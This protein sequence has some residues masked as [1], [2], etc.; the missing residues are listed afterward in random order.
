LKSNE[1]NIPRWQT[2]TELLL[3]EERLKKL[4]HSNVL[5]VGLG[6]VG[7]YAAE[8]ICRAGV[9]KMTVIDGDC[10]EETNRNRQLLALKS[11]EGQ[12][13]AELMKARL[14]EINPEAEITAIHEFLRDERMKEVL[15]EPFDCVVDAI[16][17][18]SPK[19]FLIATAMQK[20]L[21][22]IS[23]MGAGG[24]FDP[25]KVEIADISKSYQCKLARA[26]RKRLHRM[27]IYSGF[28]VVFSPEETS[29]EAV[30]HL[31]FGE[32]ENQKS[33][34]GT[35][36]YMPPIFGCFCASAVIEELLAD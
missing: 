30:T 7:A 32:A 36:S 14:S 23:S 12:S 19:V 35:I 29:E 27:D 28:K 26:I 2:R 5:I 13:K 24:K 31:E 18:L 25:S 4:H 21:K 15:E 3:K 8:L 11:Y 9:G 10:V 34:V 33:V 6:G 16:D 22:I 1:K 20:G 17:T